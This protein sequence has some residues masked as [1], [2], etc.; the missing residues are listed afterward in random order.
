[1]KK[2]LLILSLAIL[3]CS[4]PVQ[5]TL[6]TP[7]P[8]PTSAPV[9]TFTQTPLPTPGP[10]TEKNPLI[11]ALGPSPHPSNDT[12]T[13]GK[14]IAEFI[15]KQTGYRVV[16]VIPSSE[17]DLV[18]AFGKGNAHIAM[19]TPYGYLLA[20][21][22]LS[23]SAALASVHNGDAFYGAQII[24]NR[25]GEFTS[26]YDAA[27]DDNT[28]D[29]ETALK[30]FQGKKPCWSDTVSP[31]GYVVPFGLLNQAKVEAR[32][33]A[34]LESQPSV[35]RAVYAADICD[36]GATF[37]D[38]RDSKVLESDYPDVMEKVLVAW[39]IPKIIP[40]E[41]ISISTTLPIE[42][43]RLIQRAFVD[44]MLTA[45]GKSAM[46]TVFGIDEAQVVEDEK[47]DEFAKYVAD[48]G[49]DLREL[50]EK[51]LP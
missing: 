10:G 16:T 44:L 4:L 31:S 33:G 43:R 15:E 50:V 42:M 1:M 9:P 40:Y 29:P 25:D 38:A 17:L 21:S 32:S 34:F 19:L 5:L 35:V 24:I 7:T 14:L 30:Q 45:D 36:F 27:L 11:L 8:T 2:L 49:L 13:A 46:Q 28:S 20:R 12:I 18:D 47:Y 41:N 37:V 22:N 51:S 23:A 48:S 26:Y 39:R 3:G 6:G